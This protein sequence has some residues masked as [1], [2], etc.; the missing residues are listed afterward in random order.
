V[1]VRLPG[2]R[3]TLKLVRAYMAGELGYLVECVEEKT[4]H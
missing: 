2:T 4:P 3:E 1:A